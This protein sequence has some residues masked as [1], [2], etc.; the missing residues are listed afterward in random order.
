MI[1]PRGRGEKAVIVR[2]GVVPG[3]GPGSA[4]RGNERLLV[5]RGL[6]R[7]RDDA[8][9]SHEEVVAAAAMNRVEHEA[10]RHRR[11]ASPATSRR[12][13]G[14]RGCRRARRAGAP[15]T[16]SCRRAAAAPGPRSACARPAQTPPAPASSSRGRPC[17]ALA[18]RSGRASLARQAN[19]PGCPEA[20]ARERSHTRPRAGPRGTG[21]PRVWRWRCDRETSSGW[22]VSRTVRRVTADPDGKRCPREAK[23]PAAGARRAERE[24]KRQR[25]KL[26][27][28]TATPNAHN[29]HIKGATEKPP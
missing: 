21:R 10:A 22:C 23:A 13:P 3:R 7:R 11:R 24:G 6:R 8:R 9:G 27:Q 2:P 20:L 17:R 1:V 18:G 16:R 15:E 14:Q 5:E 4:R 25:F 28:S 29:R 12:R 26:G 19:P